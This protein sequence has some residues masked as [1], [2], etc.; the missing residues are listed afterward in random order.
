MMRDEARQTF[1]NDPT[2]IFKKQRDRAALDPI[3]EPAARLRETLKHRTPTMR[4]PDIKE[5]CQR[6]KQKPSS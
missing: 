2:S 4:D 5:L 3:R 6:F 1:I